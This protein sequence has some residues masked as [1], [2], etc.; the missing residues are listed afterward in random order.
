MNID[1]RWIY[2]AFAIVAG[3]VVGAGLAWLSRRVLNRGNRA[4]L[5]AI[6]APT[7]TFL[8]WLSVTT[9]I[10]TA[11]GFTSPDTLEPIPAEV[12]AWLPRALAGGLILLVGYAAGGAISAAVA[13]GAQRAIGHRPAALERGLRWGIMSAATVLALGNLGVKTTSL[14]ILIAGVIF[15]IG[16]AG[17]L[18][19][20][21]GGQ[22]VAANVAGGRALANELHIG[23]TLTTRSH[24]GTIVRF[25]PAVCVLDND[26]VTTLIPYSLL[27]AEPFDIHPAASDRDNDI[28]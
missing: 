11:I 27:L 23:D 19:A 15:A 10:V 28:T 8:F 9:G 21:L 22:A 24:T 26:G 5:R 2:A 13:A 14:Q 16:L 7:A 12:L 4:A 17:A 3:F 6:A 20:G 1:H 25:R 18:I